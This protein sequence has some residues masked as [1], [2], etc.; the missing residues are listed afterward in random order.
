M[1]AQD[2]G[3]LNE[4]RECL[5]DS[6]DQVLLLN[7]DRVQ[8]QWDQFGV[9]LQDLDSVAGLGEVV[10]GDDSEAL[11]IGVL[12]LQVLH[13]NRVK[14]AVVCADIG[15]RK[16][17]DHDT[18]EH[19]GELFLLQAFCLSVFENESEKLWPRLLRNQQF[20]KLT[21]HISDVLLDHWDG[22]SH[23]S[24]KKQVLGLGLIILR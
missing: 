14:L 5:K 13:D 10:D 12:R 6:L 11:Q 22:L 2:L 4:I 20:A 1:G 7:I 8:D 24:L 15:G 18:E 21:N 19:H 16:I 9:L 17:L 23:E 3:R